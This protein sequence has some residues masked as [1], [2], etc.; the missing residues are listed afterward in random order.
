VLLELGRQ[1]AERSRGLVEGDLVAGMEVG[2]QAKEPG[3]LVLRRAGAG[4]GRAHPT[5]MTRP[6]RPTGTG[7]RPPRAA[8][9][10][11]RRRGP[12]RTPGARRPGRRRSGA[13]GPR[14]SARPGR[15]R[16]AR[17][18]TRYAG[19]TPPLLAGPG[20]RPPRP[21]RPARGV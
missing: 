1:H 16:R 6:P 13:A 12:A 7:G 15:R 20:R 18:G 9:P 21:A 4:G 17:P 19:A 14:E 8:S 5:L 3:D 10:G 11:P 2:H